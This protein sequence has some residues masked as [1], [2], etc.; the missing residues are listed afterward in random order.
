MVILQHTRAT[1]DSSETEAFSDGQTL[2]PVCVTIFLIL[3]N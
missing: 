1:F 3:I 2:N